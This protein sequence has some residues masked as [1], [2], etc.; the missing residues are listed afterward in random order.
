[1]K[2]PEDLWRDTKLPQLLEVEQALPSLFIQNLYVSSPC[3]VL[4]DV[5]TG[6]LE[7]QHRLCWISADDDG[8]VDSLLLLC[9]N[10]IF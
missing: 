3:Q 1:M 7:S 4:G 10:T 2:S 9:L 5:D 6:I 8:L